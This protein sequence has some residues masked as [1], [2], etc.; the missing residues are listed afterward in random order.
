MSEIN[1][2]VSVD[3][4]EVAGN[5]IGRAILWWKTAEV[6]AG[7]KEND[8]ESMDHGSTVSHYCQG[9]LFN[10]YHSNETGGS[11]EI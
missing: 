5:I 9:L 7:G 3:F 4:R 6:A 11:Q 8:E 2:C 1:T 10:E